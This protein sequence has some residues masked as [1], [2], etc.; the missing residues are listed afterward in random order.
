MV[1]GR[2]G[3]VRCLCRWREKDPRPGRRL[4]GTPRLGRG[5]D[6]VHRTGR[7]GKGV[8]SA[9]VALTIALAVALPVTAEGTEDAEF[10]T[11]QTLTRDVEVKEAADAGSATVGK[12]SAG[13]PVV[14]KSGEGEW[15]EIICQ[16]IHGFVPADALQ[17]FVTEAES[18]SSEME[19]VGEEEQRLVEEHELYLRQ[20]RISL[21]IVVLISLIFGIGIFTAIRNGKQ[22]RSSEKEKKGKPSGNRNPTDKT[23]G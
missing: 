23:E 9:L 20:R 1:F 12:L 21:V 4:E 3:D 22:G 5:R 13:T 16:D 17:P 6:C 11:L 7:K 14:E 10:G 15:R 18:L 2:G 19:R 8:F